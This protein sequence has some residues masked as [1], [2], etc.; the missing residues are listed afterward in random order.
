M[1]D[2][3]AQFA[4]PR[5]AFVTG[6]SRGVGRA[7]ADRL[8]AAGWQ[9]RRYSRATGG[10]VMH[11][12]AIHEAIGSFAQEDPFEPGLDLLVCAASSS[13]AG[14]LQ[15][16]PEGEPIRTI[17]TDLS[18][19]VSSV[20]AALPWLAQR[21]GS[22]VVLFSSMAAFHGVPGFAAYSAVKAA[23]RV[24]A[25]AMRLEL[26]AGH[27][28]FLT[29]VLGRLE[30]EGDTRAWTERGA[31]ALGP[32]KRFRV[33]SSASEP[34]PIAKVADEVMNRLGESGELFLPRSLGWM[35]LVARHVPTGFRQLMKMYQRRRLPSSLG[36]RESNTS[37]STS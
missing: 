6:G 9:V 19:T 23:I 25:D 37:D 35:N 27:P 14:Y 32:M 10:N 13:S 8:E 1:M 18:G 30:G 29:L 26:P 33:F 21:K 5:R 15:M 11:A 20:Q 16:L 3:Q 34:F 36:I 12:N 2:A 17:D 4:S 7:I 22:T 28:T 31:T 24:F